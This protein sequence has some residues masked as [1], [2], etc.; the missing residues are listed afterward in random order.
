MM[1]DRSTSAAEDLRR[2]VDWGGARVS[3]SGWLLCFRLPLRPLAGRGAGFGAVW[4]TVGGVG[5]EGS[6]ARPVEPLRRA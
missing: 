5:V 3:T 2:I 6:D 4:V 1:G